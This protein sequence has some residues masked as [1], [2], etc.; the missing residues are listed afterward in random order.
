MSQNV[1][2]IYRYD[3]AEFV[4]D[5]AGEPVLDAQGHKMVTSPSLAYILDAA[6]QP[7]VDADGFKIL[8]SKP[9]TPADVY[10]VSQE[11]YFSLGL[12][13]KMGLGTLTDH[14]FEADPDVHLP[15]TLDKRVFECVLNFLKAFPHPLTKAELDEMDELH[16]K[17]LALGDDLPGEEFVLHLELEPAHRAFFEPYDDSVQGGHFLADVL[18]ATEFLHPYHFQDLCCLYICSL[19]GDETP[20]EM[21]SKMTLTEKGIAY[22]DQL[23]AEREEEILAYRAKLKAEMDEKYPIDPPLRLPAAVRA[24]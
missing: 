21:V 23:K 19:L 11:V 10:E 5:S 1:Y 22:R 14:G 17:E 24:Q 13:V 4:L 2:F 3:P 20:E 12:V 7:V 15:V 18:I 9:S 16:R 6:G 8:A